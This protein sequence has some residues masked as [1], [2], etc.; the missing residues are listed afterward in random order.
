MF[1]SEV[2]SA[3]ITALTPPQLAQVL[4]LAEQGFGRRTAAQLVGIHIRQ[5]PPGRLRDRQA[6]R[7]VLPGNPA[8]RIPRPATPA[9]RPVAS[10]RNQPERSYLHPMT[11]ATEDYAHRSTR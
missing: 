5:I 2:A 1:L 8:G 7:P 6:P 3:A 11:V 9:S 4:E 10:G